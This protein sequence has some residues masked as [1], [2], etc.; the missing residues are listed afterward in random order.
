MMQSESMCII[1]CYSLPMMIQS[2]C[3]LATIRRRPYTKPL[4]AKETSCDAFTFLGSQLIKIGFFPQI[5]E[6]KCDQCRLKST[7]DRWSA[8]SFVGCILNPVTCTEEWFSCGFSVFE[9]H[10]LKH[11]INF[12][13]HP[14]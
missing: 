4:P 7:R 9:A 8:I 5:A 10:V 6:L 12:G 2:R 14:S 11:L 1:P 3:F 13:V